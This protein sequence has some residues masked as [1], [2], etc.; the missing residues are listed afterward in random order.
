MEGR[1]GS[2]ATAPNWAPTPACRTARE[3]VSCGVRRR[4][5]DRAAAELV[6]S[7]GI[8]WILRVGTFPLTGTPSGLRCPAAKNGVRPSA[9]PHG[10]RRGG[11][12]ERTSALSVD[13]VGRGH[14][15]RRVPTPARRA[16]LARHAPRPASGSSSRSDSPPDL[17][18]RGC[19]RLHRAVRLR[20][21]AV[22]G[23]SLVAGPGSVQP[24]GLRTLPSTSGISPRHPVAA[25]DAVLVP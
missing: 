25:A 22:R 6:A 24:G 13:R 14:R 8:A 11:I 17:R 16:R 2:D 12:L 20:E 3:D 9:V 5:F 18:D 23:G 4:E 7:R 10:R 19:P 21:G 1:L 15:G